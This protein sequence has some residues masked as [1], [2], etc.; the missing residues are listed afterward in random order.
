MRVKHY[1]VLI[2]V[3]CLVGI[4]LT[5]WYIQNKK[6]SMDQPSKSASSSS[7]PALIATGHPTRHVF[8]RRLPWLGMVE[9]RAK[10]EMTAQVAGRIESIDVKDQAR[11]RKGQPV[12]RL[13]GPQVNEMQANLDSEIESLKSQVNLAEQTTE[14]LKQN[15]EVKSATK[16]Q[17]AK[18][19]AEKIK[20]ETQLHQAQVRLQTLG[21]Q[22]RLAAPMNGIFTNRRV[23]PGQYVTAGQV[24]GEILAADQLRIAASLFPPQGSELQG[25]E[26]TILLGDSRRLTG[27]VG[28]VLPHAQDTG[29]TTIWIEGAAIDAHLHPGQMVEGNVD[30]DVGTEDL[31]VPET[32]II[33]DKQE[34]PYIFVRRGGSYEP[35]QVKLGIVQDGWAEVLSGLEPEQLVVTQGAYELYYRQFN[36]QFKVQD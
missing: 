18:A 24:I 9:S 22:L 12:V 32:A 30:L 10:V 17:L 34:H 19:Q 8:I 4:T 28:S 20:L 27:K 15:L 36:E 35:R 7:V 3:V 1:L 23:S 21:K 11:V 25:K 31:A 33:F 26:A 16:D 29:A 13:G 2:T 14:R 6:P 5:Y